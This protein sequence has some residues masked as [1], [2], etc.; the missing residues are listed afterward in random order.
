MHPM[1]HMHGVIALLRKST[2]EFIVR[3]LMNGH[4]HLA[5]NILDGDLF[6]SLSKSLNF[7]YIYI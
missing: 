2:R 5:N 7:I 4:A 1:A 6:N 3:H